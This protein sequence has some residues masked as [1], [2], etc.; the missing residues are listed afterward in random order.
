MQ[1]DAC[2]RSI[3]EH[4][5]YETVTVLAAVDRQYAAAYRQVRRDNRV[6][7]WMADETYGFESFVRRFLA[8]H[9]RVVFHTD[10]DVFFRDTPAVN[11]SHDPIVSY[12]LGRNAVLQH[13]TGLAQRPPELI[14]WLWREA[15]G[16]FGYP[17]AVN[18]TV[19]RT[20]WLLPLLD[21]PFANPTQLE[22]GLAYRADRL[23]PE[24]MA[25]PDLSCCVSLPHNVV[26]VSS[27]CPR[28]DNPVWQPQ[29]L[30]AL[31]AAGWRIDYRRM[32]WAK[33]AGAHQEVP[34]VLRRVDVRASGI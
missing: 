27:G 23:G 21:F 16:D 12:R 4:A 30:L 32:E 19:Y 15:E 31:Y 17:L 29:S 11:W 18:A 8:N 2:L 1:L 13:P 10:D 22:A 33:V 25:C 28:G 34:L 7:L 5:P 14:P 6:T 20:G 26:S 9:E 24:W 3:R